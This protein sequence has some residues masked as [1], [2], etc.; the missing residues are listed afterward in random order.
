MILG[1]F[2][3]MLGTGGTALV[4]KT[5]G[6]KNKEKANS[7]FSLIIYT[8][9]VLGII[10][11]LVG[12]FTVEPVSRWMASLTSGNTE[13]MVNCAIRYGRILMLGIP[14]FMLQ[15]VFQSFFVA[16]EKP[17][18]GFYFILAAGLTNIV[19][20]ALL[21]GIFNLSIEGAAIATIV[22]YLIAGLGPILYFIFKDDVLI[23]IG[24]ATID[25]KALGKVC[26]NGISEFATNITA[27]IVG[28]F[29]NAQLL[30]YSG[31]DGVS[32]Y[33]IIMYVS[34]VFISIFI[35]YSIGIAPIIG[36]NYGAKNKPELHNIFTRSLILIS[37]TGLIMFSLSQILAYPFSLFFAHGNH[38]LVNLSTRAMRI[39]SF[40]FLTCG[41]SM[42]GSSFFTALNNGLISAI[43]S[44][45]RSI[46][47]ELVAVLC[48]PLLWQTDGIWAS[49][50]F[51][52]IGS[53]VMV[54]IF[55]V[56]Q[57]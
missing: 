51:A 40:V 44:L 56:T 1:G 38:D 14:F 47:F 13:N 33:G 19:G 27:S 34:Y 45:V 35:G 8:T 41:F 57:N 17:L 10:L 36:Y 53:S 15:N 52:E 20:D 49:A 55:F 50:A 46:G 32:A 18:I 26:T 30:T 16:A 43:V 48:L 4:S 21:V 12:Y 3:F 6:E 2:G 9:I 24:K 5:L 54:I 25:F 23:S 28:M 29:Y 42:F 31:V 7:F 22:G 37:I 11:G 39:Y